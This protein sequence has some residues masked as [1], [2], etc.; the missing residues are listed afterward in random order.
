MVDPRDRAAAVPLDLL[1]KAAIRQGES[2]RAGDGV[3]AVALT[4]RKKLPRLEGFRSSER[5]LAAPARMCAGTSR[6]CPVHWIFNNGGGR[7]ALRGDPIRRLI[8]SVL[9]VEQ[10][11]VVP[12]SEPSGPQSL[13]PK[14]PLAGSTFSP[15]AVKKQVHGLKVQI[16]EENYCIFRNSPMDCLVAWGL[17]GDCDG[18]F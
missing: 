16:C 2:R 11:G 9:G 7:G 10:A 13:P 3:R 18:G 5:C 4:R 6:S 14:A 1:D 12:V 15:S 17:W 8:A